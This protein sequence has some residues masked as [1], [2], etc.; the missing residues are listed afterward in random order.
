MPATPA[1][2][3][4][5]PVASSRRTPPRPPA[6]AAGFSHRNLPL[7]LLQARERVIGRFRPLLNAHGIT[8]QQWRVI[9]ALLETGPLEP[10]EIV[11]LCNLSSPSLAGVLARMEELGY[12]NRTRMD[13]DARRLRVALTAKSR[14][15]AARLA[16]KVEATYAEIE[17]LV[18]SPLLRQLYTTLDDLA[19][20]L[21][22]TESSGDEA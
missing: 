17:R 12:V 14:A 6:R 19:A 9:R 3:R 21:G 13:H 16:P 2:P 8:E 4:R 7:L 1:R 15:L 22:P 20:K 10:R 18:G 11:A 5:Q